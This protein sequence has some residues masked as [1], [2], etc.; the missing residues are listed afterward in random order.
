MLRFNTF[1][2]GRYLRSKFVEGKYLLASEATDLE[3]EV[4]DLLRKVVSSTLGDVAVEDAWKVER[5]SDTQILIKPGQAWFKGL[6]VAMRSGKDQLVSGAVLSIGTVPVGTVVTDDS[7]G[8]GKIITF[9][10]GGTTPTNLYRIVISVREELLTEVDDPFLQNVNLT[11]STAQKIRLL[12]QLNIVPESLQTESPVPYRDETSA[13]LAV[14]NFPNAGGMA[15]PNFVNQIVVTPT[16]AGNGELIALNLISGAEGIDGRDVELVL[17][18][19]TGLGGGNPIPNSPSLQQAFSNG[20][21]IDSNGNIFHINAVFNDTVSTQVVIRIDKEPDQPNPQIVNTFPFTL[22]K[23]DVFVTDDSNGVPQG[24]LHWY[25]A[26]L[27][28]SSSLGIVHDSRVTDLRKSVLQTEDYQDKFQ[29]M[30]N[31]IPTGGGDVSFGV[32]GADL[33]DWSAD[34]TVLNSFGPSSILEDN[35][36]A[37]IEDGAVIYDLDL[38]S[39]GI[40]SKGNEAVT[41]LSGG[42]TITVAA[43]D[44]LSEVRLGNIIKIGAEVAEITSIN[45]VSKQLGVSPSIAGT[46]A[47]DI[48]LDSF[49]NDTYVLNSNSYV[50]AVR[51]DNKVWIG[52]GALELEDGETNQIGDGTSQE[53]LQYIGAP[54]ETTA[55]PT[56]SSATNITQGG[57]LTQAIGELDDALDSV[58]D[59][60]EAPLYDERIQYPS[61]LVASTNIPIPNNSRDSGNPHVYV[62]ASGDMIVFLNQLIKFPTIDYVEVDGSTIAFNYDLP[63]NAEVRFR[64]AVVGGGNSGGGGGGDL[65]D[66][67][68]NGDT[69]T[70]TIGNPF[71]VGGSAAKVAQ[72]NGDIG[73]TGV[74]DPLGIEFETTGSNPLGSGK[75]GFWVNT[76]DELVYE[77]G[78]TAKNFTQS[79]DNLESGL[80]VN[81]LS[82]LMF[83]NTGITIPKGTPVYSP[84]AGEIEP[85]RGSVDAEARVIGITAEN[86]PNGQN[87]L[88]AYAGMLTGVSGYTHGSYLYLDDTAGVLV[89]V[90]PTLGPYSAGFNVVIVGLVEDDNIMLQISHVGVL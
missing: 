37:I 85:A 54:D 1:R 50:F 52:G 80:G 18:N 87:G 38:D 6:P 84:T 55:N 10:S 83:N 7:S 57:S 5:L 72:F 58:F 9:N 69:I 61:G 14:T 32:V 47:A 59:A 26:T 62:P 82:R 89:D 4:M 28:W 86:I 41:I 42:A 19:N 31:L 51:K 3:L 46:G 8:A 13:S 12:F 36:V 75:A 60:L 24:K 63:T 56:Y 49:A 27:D 39:G 33:L 25:L 2:S 29:K 22:M 53:L 81:S 34:V 17:R 16:A 48:Y 79:I 70:T 45:D 23:R 88:V 74:I 73:V 68:D 15:S 11:E 71:T 90:E 40:V 76:S 77:D 78:T 30:L 66:A 43:L 65:Q 20:K 21:L 67:Y 64:D 44:D 35:T